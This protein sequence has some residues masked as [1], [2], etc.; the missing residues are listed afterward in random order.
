[1]ACVIPF[2]ELVPNASVRFQI[3]NG[4][5][6]LSVRDLIMVYCVTDRKNASKIWN[7]TTDDKRTEVS[8][9]M[10]H[11]QFPGPGEKTQDVITFEGAVKILMWL[12]GNSAKDFRSKVTEILT[13]YLAGD[14][15]LIKEIEQNAESSH[16]VNVMARAAME[17][18]ESSE[19]EMFKKRA[20]L[21]AEALEDLKIQEM[22]HQIKDRTRRDEMNYLMTSVEFLKSLNNGKLD[23][24]TALQ[25][26]DCIKNITFAGTQVPTITNGDPSS[27]TTL[28][29]QSSQGLTLSTVVI[30]MR[31]KCTD[32]ELKSMGKQLAVKYR[33]KY[34]TSPSQH[35]QYCGGASRPVNSY[36]EKDRDLMEEVIREF[37]KSRTEK[38]DAE[39][40]NRKRNFFQRSL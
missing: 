32:D 21:R 27:Q 38:K 2:D 40:K 31:V 5:H 26:S 20:R 34:G 10:H 14:S 23:D 11:F 22:A 29:S 17:D 35:T 6:Y 33:E 16:P 4:K 3:I 12:P 18:P 36:T 13:R 28:L 8:P 39:L 25:Y 24:R 15:T 9:F 19:D 37:D 1:M 7:R 30:S